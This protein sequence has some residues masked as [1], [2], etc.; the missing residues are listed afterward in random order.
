M[1]RLST[2]ILILMSFLV[3]ACGFQLCGLNQN[4]SNQ[5]SHIYIEETSA[6][7]SFQE[8]VKTLISK[9]GGKLVSKAAATKA[10]YLTPIST[11]SRQI[12]L[13]SSGSLKEYERTYQTT[14][15]VV[16][17][18]AGVQLGRR[19]L[20][21][22]Q[23]LQLDSLTPQAGEEQTLISLAAAENDLAQAVMSYLSTF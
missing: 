13:S 17:I 18:K 6:N 10:I 19:T 23:Y 9:S 4:L 20:S 8:K 5:F 12:S 3:T 1:R 22:T 14:V 11:S 16:D 7:P 15:T 2:T 21:N